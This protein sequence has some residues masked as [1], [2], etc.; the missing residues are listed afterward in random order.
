MCY[1]M[2]IMKHILVSCRR[3]YVC[4]KNDGRCGSGFEKS[5]PED[6]GNDL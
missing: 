1:T 6:S 2:Y 3:L 4:N 5:F